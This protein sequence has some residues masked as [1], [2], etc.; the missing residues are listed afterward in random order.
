VRRPNNYSKT[1]LIRNQREECQHKVGFQTSR[2]KAARDQRSLPY[3]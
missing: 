1:K 3:I 2:N